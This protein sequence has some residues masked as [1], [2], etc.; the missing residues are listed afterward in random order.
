MKYGFAYFDLYHAM[1]G[2]GSIINWV[3]HNPAW[4]ISDYIH[5]TRKGGEE[6]AGYL[7]N[8]LKENFQTMLPV[9]ESRQQQS[10]L[11]SLYWKRY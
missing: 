4:A 3:H 7:M 6:V 8:G 1:G 9:Q 5:Y 2:K 11:D 10:L